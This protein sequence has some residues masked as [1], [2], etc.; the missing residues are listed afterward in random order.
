MSRNPAARLCAFAVLALASVA[1]TG[2]SS[3]YY[4][5]WKKLGYEKRDILVDRVEEA[6]D[7]QQDA[8]EQVKTTL[9]RLQEITGATGGELES[10]YKKFNSEYEDAVEAAEDVREQIASVEKVA[11]DLFAEWE[12]EIAAFDNATYRQ[13]SQQQLRETKDRYQKLVSTMRAAEQS[14]QPVLTAFHDQVLRLKHNLNAAAIA[15]LEGTAVKIQTDVN[16]LVKQMEA[17]IAE[18]D[19]FISQMKK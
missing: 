14:M 17:S 16:Q 5:M 9:E 1:S 6:R 13:E 19:A 18:A 4:S 12:K 8:K 3:A 2:C 7:E 11:G 15:S 10:K